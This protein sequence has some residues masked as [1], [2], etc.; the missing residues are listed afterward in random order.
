MSNIG[1][2][3]SQHF[4]VTTRG[5][6]RHLELK[7]PGLVL[8]Y[9]KGGNDGNCQKFDP[10][11]YSVA[12]TD[13]RIKYAIIDVEGSN[14]EIINRSRNTTT[15]ISV[16]PYMLFYNNGKP[17]S[18]YTNKSKSPELIMDFINKSLQHISTTQQQTSQPKYYAPENINTHSNRH[19]IQ[20]TSNGPGGGNMSLSTSS[21][22]DM[23]GKSIDN[24]NK[25]LEI[26]TE[27]I[28]YDLPWLV[29]SDTGI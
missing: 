8:V 12:N 15:P 4:V 18:K 3:N 20:H 7:V 23:L 27:R 29:S 26:P 10:I 25:T 5:D 19:E 21:Q 14:R 16:I 2:L 9:F 22:R 13:K 11:F 24:Q 17:Y 6:K 1:S 28:P